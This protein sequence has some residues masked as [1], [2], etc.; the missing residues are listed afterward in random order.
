MSSALRS[1]LKRLGFNDATILALNK[2]GFKVAMDLLVPDEDDFNRLPKY[3]ESWRD[4]TA[5]DDA[6]VRIPLLALKKLKAMRHWVKE[7]RCLGVAE[8][9]AAH[10]TEAVLLATLAQLDTAAEEKAARSET[11][12][13]K[14]VELTDLAQWPSFYELLVTFLGRIKGAASTPLSYLI[15]EHVVVTAEMLAAEYDSD[16]ARLI[17]TTALEGAHFDHDNRTLYDELKPLLVKGP[18]WPFIK[19]FD[20]AKDG[21]GAFLAL[22][23]Q[24]EGTSSK[25]TRKAKAYATISSLVYRGPRRGFNFDHY[26]TEHQKAHNEL[27]QL[28]EAVPESKKV[29]DFLKGIQDPSLSVAKTVV[30]ADPTKMEDFQACQLYLGTCVQNAAAQ[31]KSERHIHSVERDGGGEGGNKALVD[32]IKGGRY[33]LEQ[34]KTL[35]KSDRARVLQFRDGSTGSKKRDKRRAKAHKRRLAKA[36]SDR[37]TVEADSEEETASPKA[38]AGSQFG[39]NGNKSKK[40]KGK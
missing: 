24:T 13:T 20:K 5:N 1:V 3:L 14:P 25:L 21:R 15:R 9:N 4:P 33:S 37:D 34:W 28:E 11:E 10:F 40:A 32:K 29:T 16:A 22:Q 35:S 31:A 7:Q 23:A 12:V 38:D 2:N 39:S 26:V 36:K 19:K 18:G 6:Q 17:E 30:L 8:P 27:S